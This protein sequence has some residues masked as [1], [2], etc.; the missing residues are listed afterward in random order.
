MIAFDEAYDKIMSQSIR[1]SAE[2]VSLDQA[3]G[4]ILAED[5]LSDIDMPPFNKSAMDGY[6]CRRADLGGPLIV[7]E[8]I[9]AGVTPK[10]AVGPGQCSKI[11]TGA[12]VPEGADCVIMVEWTETVAD[13]TVRF[14]GQ[15]AA[16]NI[17]LK[18]ED[19]RTGD[20]VLSAGE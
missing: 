15:N 12:P 19:V 4:R 20:C 5:V 13:Q 16:D 7:V 17:C 11:M 9:P 10:K 3:M 1:W 14:T 6:A 2:R 8:V 18:G